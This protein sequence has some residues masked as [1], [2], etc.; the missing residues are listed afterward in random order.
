MLAGEVIFM[1]SYNP[2]EIM[3]EIKTHRVSVLVSVPMRGSIG[4]LNVAAAG[5]VLC[6]EVSR[7]R[8][9]HP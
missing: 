7:Q 8:A 1:R 5:A 4:S 6:Y 2:Q 3:R 9:H